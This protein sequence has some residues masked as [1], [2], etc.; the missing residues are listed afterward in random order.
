MVGVAQVRILTAHFRQ[1]GRQ[2]SPDKS[3][4]HSDDTA[5]NPGSQDQCGGMHLLRDD[6]GIDE[7][8]GTDDAAHDQHGGVKEAKLTCQTW[9]RSGWLIRALRVNHGIGLAAEPRLS[10][11]GTC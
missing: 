7:N 5:K 4:A 3:A 2:F 11:S 10:L 6:V 9:L 8:A 1:R